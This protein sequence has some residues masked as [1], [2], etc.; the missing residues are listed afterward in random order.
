MDILKD[1][2]EAST[3]HGLAYISTAKVSLN[4]SRFT[5][6]TFFFGK[7]LQSC[8][9][10][11]LCALVSSALG[12]WLASRTRSGRTTLLQP[13]PMW[14][15]TLCS[16]WWRSALQYGPLPWLDKAGKYFI[17]WKGQ[18][19]IEGSSLQ[20]FLEAPHREYVTCCSNIKRP[21]PGVS[22][23]PVLAKTLQLWERLW[24]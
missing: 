21:E 15:M 20:H 2:L 18:G 4:P 6:R 12:S 9:G 16:P 10:L 14:L 7:S 5:F 13:R 11:E 17:F 3:I 19:G 8:S 1:F 24:N 23:I 22:G